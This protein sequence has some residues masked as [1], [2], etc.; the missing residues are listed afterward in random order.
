MLSTDHIKFSVMP[1]TSSMSHRNTLR[2][3][4]DYSMKKLPCNTPILYASC[5]EGI[6]C[7]VSFW[8]ELFVYFAF[9]TFCCP[10]TTWKSQRRNLFLVFKLECH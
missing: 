1:T 8:L 3:F 10:T 2:Y 6:K 7:F 9:E 4:M 5:T